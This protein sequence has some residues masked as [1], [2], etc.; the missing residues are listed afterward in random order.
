MNDIQTP[1]LDPDFADGYFNKGLALENLGRYDEAIAAFEET[2][3]RVPELAE[4]WHHKGIAYEKL[5]KDAEAVESFV[6][7]K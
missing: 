6:R 1:T 2:I 3:Y 5:G 7:A 4:A